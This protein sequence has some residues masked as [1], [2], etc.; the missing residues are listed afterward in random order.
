M[1]RHD[2]F[3]PIVPGQLLRTFLFRF[4][5]FLVLRVGN[6]GWVYLRLFVIINSLR[7]FF[8]FLPL[9]G[10]LGFSDSYLLGLAYGLSPLS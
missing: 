5:V 6:R 7:L 8:A 4:L 3:S 9:A 10:F 2:G 1:L